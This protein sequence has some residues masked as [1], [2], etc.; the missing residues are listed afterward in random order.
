MAREGK[1]S[2]SIDD[3]TFAALKDLK[4]EQDTWDE[5]LLRGAQL[6]NPRKG[7]MDETLRE[8]EHRHLSFCRRTENGWE[9]YS[10]N[11]SGNFLVVPPEEQRR[12]ETREFFEEQGFESVTLIEALEGD[13]KKEEWVIYEE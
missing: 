13:D 1:A 7:D 10:R 11:E 6:S 8:N 4:H 5:F 9:V 12:R 2:I 3:E